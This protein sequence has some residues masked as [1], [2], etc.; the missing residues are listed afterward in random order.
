MTAA[1]AVVQLAQGW[2]CGVLMRL[3]LMQRPHMPQA[4]LLRDK[5]TVTKTESQI[6]AC[7]VRNL[8]MQFSRRSL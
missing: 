4:S 6:S 3:A 5:P 8:L 7:S 2:R 1:A